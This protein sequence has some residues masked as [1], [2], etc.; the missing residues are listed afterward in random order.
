MGSATFAA[1]VFF[2]TATVSLSVIQLKRSAS[3]ESSLLWPEE[4]RT[5]EIFQRVAPS[6]VHVTSEGVEQSPLPKPRADEDPGPGVGSGF[7]WNDRGYIVTNHHLVDHRG[8]ANVTLSDGSK[9]RA[10]LVGVDEDTDLAVL[11]IPVAVGMLEPLELGSSADLQVGQKVFSIGTP[12]G[13]DQSLTV[14]VVSA[15]NRG[16]RAMNGKLIDGVVQ[17]DA[18][19]NPGSSGGPLLDSS[20]AV[21]GV[22]TAIHDSSLT[23][24]GVSFAVPV[25]TIRRIVP[26]I[27]QLGV[28]PWPEL[29][30][31]LAETEFSRRFLGHMPT[32]AGRN[33]ILVIEVEADSPASRAKI[34]PVMYGDN[35]MTVGDVIVGID[36]ERVASRDDL[37]EVLLQKREG[38]LVLLE[39]IRAVSTVHEKLVFGSRERA[40]LPDSNGS[41]N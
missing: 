15:L 10:V 8:V 24:V 27:I 16:I 29:G 39:L 4:R 2:I 34:V 37:S 36:G 28:E 30:L 11:A 3:D 35:F 19:I 12:F 20:G 22:S 14:G 18:A 38:D 9:Y 33:G 17:T 26:R 32:E 6:V 21:I 41:G 31:V 25:D 40:V 5:I 13:L 1:L 23:N 7:V